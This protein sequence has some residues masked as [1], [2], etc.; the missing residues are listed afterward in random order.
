[1][2]ESLSYA[3]GV[4]GSSPAPPIET[5]TGRWTERGSLVTPGW[6]NPGDGDIPSI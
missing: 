4:V 5:D 1:M 6:R 2:G 3:Q